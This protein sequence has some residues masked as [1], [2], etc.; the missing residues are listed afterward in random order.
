MRDIVRYGE[1]TLRLHQRLAQP[2]CQELGLS[3]KELDVLTFLY[4]NPECNTARDITRLLRIAKSNLSPLLDDL[5][6]QGWLRS[7]TD[8]ENRRLKRLTLCRERK[9]EL[10]SIAEYRERFFAIFTQ[11]FA[12]EEVETLHTLLE[13]MDANALR[14]LEDLEENGHA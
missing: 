10:E 5:E 9:R 3:C 8:P 6:K 12:Q 2:L 13:R 14:A 11:G 1:H 7:E 4:N